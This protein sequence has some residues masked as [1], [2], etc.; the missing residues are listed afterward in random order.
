MNA[1]DLVELSR[2]G[3]KFVAIGERSLERLNIMRDFLGI[4]PGKEPREDGV[5]SC[6]DQEELIRTLFERLRDGI[7][8]HTRWDAMRCQGVQFGTIRT[9]L[10]PSPNADDTAVPESKLVELPMA[11]GV[12]SPSTALVRDFLS[13]GTNHRV[14][15]KIV[16]LPHPEE[17]VRSPSKH[18]VDEGSPRT[19]LSKQLLNSHCLH[20]YC[21]LGLTNWDDLASGPN[22]NNVS[23][24]RWIG[25]HWHSHSGEFG[26]TPITTL[27]SAITRGGQPHIDPLDN[28]MLAVGDVLSLEI[29]TSK[30]SS[31]FNVENGSSA[32]SSSTNRGPITAK[33]YQ[34]SKL[35]Y[36]KNIEGYLP[37]Q[38]KIGFPDV[39]AEK[40]ADGQRR[41]TR[42][43]RCQFGLQLSPGVAVALLSLEHA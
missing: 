8:N 19:Q 37:L 43:E 31:N 29:I 27:V 30:D 13:Y 23:G 7:V 14:S 5:F 16:A 34:N 10:A 32:N 6:E 26:S 35:I 15:V 38:S 3:R 20:N 21:C 36:S 11:T 42:F 18:T 22:D 33:F 24:A 4:A 39:A 40:T 17:E 1:E 41:Q 9:T 25:L 28:V 12:D 2:G